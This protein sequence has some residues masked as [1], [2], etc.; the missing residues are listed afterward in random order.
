MKKHDWSLSSR[1]I[2]ALL[3]LCV[4]I[5]VCLVLFKWYVPINTSLY[6][7][8][9]EVFQYHKYIGMFTFA[10]IILFFLDKLVD[11]KVVR[12]KRL[13]PYGSAGM[14]D[15]LTDLNVLFHFKIPVRGGG[16]LAGLIQGLGLLLVLGLAAVG[17]VAFLFNT[18]PFG[19][20]AASWVGPLYN[21]HEDLGAI[22]FWY[23]GGHVI[24]AFLHMVLPERFQEEV[25]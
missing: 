21:F 3:A 1:L 10:V 17:T 23:L 2:H 14:K 25:E 16:G 9:G 11:E 24:M 7:I 20:T 15:V 8:R 5:Q 19:K 6:A 22:L 13:Y 12:L 18:L 4:V